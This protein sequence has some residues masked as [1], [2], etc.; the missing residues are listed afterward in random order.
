[1]TDDDWVNGDITEMASHISLKGVGPTEYELNREKNR[2]SPEEKMTGHWLER[3][4][5]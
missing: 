4:D 5:D 1:M 3:L 2:S